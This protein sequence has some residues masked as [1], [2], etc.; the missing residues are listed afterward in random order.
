MSVAISRVL[1]H[2]EFSRLHQGSLASLAHL[3]RRSISPR[4]NFDRLRRA[5]KVRKRIEWNNVGLV[6]ARIYFSSSSRLARFARS[7]D[8]PVCD[9]FPAVQSTHTSCPESP[10]LFPARQSMHVEVPTSSAYFPTGHAVH[11]SEPIDE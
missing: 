2:R 11:V 10:L 1:I 9:F 5:R 7:P 4:D 8:A 3:P 6:V